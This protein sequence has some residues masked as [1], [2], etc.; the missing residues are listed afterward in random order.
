[1]CANP[2]AMAAS[3]GK[4]AVMRKLINDWKAD[5]DAIDRKLGPVLNFAI[6]SGNTQAVSLLLEH[7]VRVN[8][9]SDDFASLLP[10]LA[11]SAYISNLEMFRTILKNAEGRLNPWEFNKALILASAAGNLDIL[12]TVLEYDH[13]NGTYQSS[14]NAAVRN[15]RW[16]A[17]LKI[18]AHPKAQGLDCGELFERA[19]TG[20]ETT[21]IE[22]LQACWE[23]NRE[24]VK[25]V[26]DKCLYQAAD[27]EK[28]PT[29][30]LLLQLGANPDATGEE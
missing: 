5:V 24:A 21:L 17:C 19:A 4:I 22:L 29:V 26:L 8:Y 18:L 9:D 13:D 16:D 3:A 23:N 2:L 25:G 27:N 11:L 14:L 12:D 15:T 6:M 7:D 28:E 20:S 1:M 30:R 10:P